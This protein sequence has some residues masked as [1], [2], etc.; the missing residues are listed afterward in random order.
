MEHAANACVFTFVKRL[1]FWISCAKHVVFV[2]MP[3]RCLCPLRRLKGPFRAT[4][5]YMLQCVCESYLVHLRQPF[6]TFP[7]RESLHISRA[8]DICTGPRKNVA[9]WSQLYM[10]SM[11]ANHIASEFLAKLQHGK[12]LCTRNGVFGGQFYR[13]AE[14]SDK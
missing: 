13:F 12:N 7:G 5:L 9:Q 3:T 2:N 1:Y 11:V 10:Q 14:C 6:S 8:L 4:R